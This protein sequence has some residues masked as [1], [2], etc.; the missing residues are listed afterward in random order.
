MICTVCEQPA[1]V[2]HGPQLPC[3]LTWVVFVPR[4]SFT[5]T[6]CSGSSLYHSAFIAPTHAYLRM[7]GLHEIFKFAHLKFTV[8]GRGQTDI[9]TTSANAVTLVWGSLRLTPITSYIYTFGRSFCMITSAQI[10][11]LHIE[12][13]SHSLACIHWFWGKHSRNLAALLFDALACFCRHPGVPSSSF[14]H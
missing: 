14:D 2:C 11:V 5:P 10:T 13:D 1:L 6:L 3:V 7:F 8:Y 4:L 12:L 9:Y